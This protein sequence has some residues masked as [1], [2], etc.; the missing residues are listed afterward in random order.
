VRLTPLAWHRRRLPEASS[1]LSYPMACTRSFV[2][3]E[4][5]VDGRRLFGDVVRGR[6]LVA[7]HVLFTWLGR[8][9]RG[10]EDSNITIDSN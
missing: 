5:P 7:L 3:C 9:I 8:S 4:V 2:T 1:F 10:A 6:T